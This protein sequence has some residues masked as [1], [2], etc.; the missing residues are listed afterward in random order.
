MEGQQL[1][2]N[3]LKGNPPLKDCPISNL[4]RYKAYL[5]FT[6]NLETFFYI[7]RKKVDL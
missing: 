1:A 2:I 3:E 5:I 4:H 7:P 6:V